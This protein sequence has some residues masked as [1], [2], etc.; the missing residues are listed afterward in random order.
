MASAV[1]QFN[2]C[3]SNALTC[4]SA[5]LQNN[6]CSMDSMSKLWVTDQFWIT[7]H[8][9]LYWSAKMQKQSETQRN[10]KI[11]IF[12]SNRKC[13][14]LHKHLYLKHFL[15]LVSDATYSEVASEKQKYV[16]DRMAFELFVPSYLHICRIT[17]LAVHRLSFGPLVSRTL[18]H[19][20]SN[21][22]KKSGEEQKGSEEGLTEVLLKIRI[23]KSLVQ[24]SRTL[25]KL[26]SA[27]EHCF[28][29][30]HKQP[31]AS[32]IQSIY[33]LLM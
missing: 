28:I 30:V 7:K 23:N 10:E 8:L 32:V 9:F 11:S 2:F 13:I 14:C 21:P 17:Q 19:E 18:S 6:V 16:K 15:L 33:Q 22:W 26:Q 5:C 4:V 20:S 27:E 3:Q 24:T 25:G 29:Y 1:K 31:F 12:V